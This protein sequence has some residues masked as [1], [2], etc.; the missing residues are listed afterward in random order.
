MSFDTLIIVIF[1]AYFMWKIQ[2]SFQ[3]LAN[4]ETAKEIGLTM[5]RR[6]FR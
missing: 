6:W 5:L 1:L 2:K 4:N 3:K